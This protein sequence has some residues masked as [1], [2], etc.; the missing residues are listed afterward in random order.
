MPRRSRLRDLAGALVPRSR[1]AR[2]AAGIVLGLM[3]LG[4]I[5]AVVL[6]FLVAQGIVT[7]NLATP[8]IERAIEDRW[9]ASTRWRI[10]TTAVE[11][12]RGA[13]PS[14]SRRDISV[15]GAGWHRRRHAPSAEVELNGSLLTLSLSARRFD[16]IG[17][18]MTLRIGSKGELAVAAGKA[19]APFPLEPRRCSP[20]AT[21]PPIVPSQPAAPASPATQ[22]ADSEATPWCCARSPSG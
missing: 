15:Y 5:A 2:F 13:R 4:V 22:P 1:L 21:R 3:T 17:A 7:A 16:L 19:R 8:Y 11:T 6:Y 14:S 20:A 10:G 18:E 12:V 9:T